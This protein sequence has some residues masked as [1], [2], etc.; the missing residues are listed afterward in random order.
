MKGKYFEILTQRKNLKLERMILLIF[1]NSG[2]ITELL[3]GKEKLYEQSTLL[4]N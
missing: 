1:R 3:F 4:P 2:K